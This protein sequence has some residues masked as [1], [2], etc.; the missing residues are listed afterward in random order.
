MDVSETPPQKKMV[1]V[2]DTKPISVECWKF[3]T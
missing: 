1:K 2:M 3:Y